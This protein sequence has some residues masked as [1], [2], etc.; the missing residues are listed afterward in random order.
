MAHSHAELLKSLKAGKSTIDG[1]SL[2]G[3]GEGWRCVIEILS[4]L[5]EIA[6]CGYFIDG[7]NQKLFNTPMHIIVPC[8]FYKALER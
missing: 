2:M 7:D 4:M 8:E 1:V 5:I 6:F 3:S